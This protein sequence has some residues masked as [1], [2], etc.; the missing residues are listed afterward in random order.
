MIPQ[1]KPPAPRGESRPGLRRLRLIAL[2][3]AT[4]AVLIRIAIDMA[5]HDW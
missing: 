4:A 5:G 2:V 1:R 3:L